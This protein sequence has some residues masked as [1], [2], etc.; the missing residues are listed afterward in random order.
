[1]RDLQGEVVPLIAGYQRTD[2]ARN[3]AVAAFLEVSQDPNDALIMMDCDHI[4][5]EHIIAELVRHDPSV[6]GVVGAQAHRRGAPFDMCAFVRVDNKLH[7]IGEWEDGQLLPCVIVGTGA[8]MI[9]RWVF[10]RLDEMNIPAPY[11][12]Y[13]YGDNVPDYPSED[14]YFGLCCEAAGVPHWVDTTIKI[15]HLAM[16]PITQDDWFE[17]AEMNPGIMT[18]IQPEIEE[19]KPAFDYPN[20]TNRVEVR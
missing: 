16:H 3:R 2:T 8:I 7:T 5:P 6:Y 9:R 20:L 10:G 14:V 18:P 12:R 4:L 11:F 19:E 1:V 13:A 17:Y 15:P